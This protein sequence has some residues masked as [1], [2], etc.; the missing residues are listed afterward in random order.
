MAYFFGRDVQEILRPSRSW[1]SAQYLIPPQAE[2][3]GVVE[4]T[5]TLVD[6]TCSGFDRK[7]ALVFKELNLYSLTL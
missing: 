7:P 5:R 3:E 2:Q 4:A 1:G 6:S